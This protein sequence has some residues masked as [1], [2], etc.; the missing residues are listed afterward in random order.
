MAAK[1][2]ENAC[3]P[4]GARARGGPQNGPVSGPRNGAGTGPVLGPNS[5]R[6]CPEFPTK[7]MEFRPLF[8]TFRARGPYETGPERICPRA[9]MSL[10]EH[11][12]RD[13]NIISWSIYISRST[14]VQLIQS[15]RDRTGLGWNG[16]RGQ[17]PLIRDRPLS[18]TAPYPGPPLIR[19]R[20]LSGTAPYTRPPLI[21]D[22]PFSETAPYV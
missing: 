10:L 9:G 2:Y 20:P 7:V 14:H 21:L 17:P 1:P 3:Q 5:G 18:G 4:A 15:R 11:E 13:D 16:I 8:G 6:K 19:D 22:R 12:F